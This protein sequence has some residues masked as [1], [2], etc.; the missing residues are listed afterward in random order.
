MPSLRLHTHIDP[1]LPRLAWCARVRAYSADVVVHHGS[2]VEV[3]EQTLVDGAWDG[4]FAQMA[5]AS[6]T[7]MAGTGLSAR[8]GRLRF[9]SGSGRENRIY[10]ARRGT[11]LFVSNS[12]TFTLVAAGDSPDPTHRDHAGE[13]RRQM[14]FGPH[15]HTPYALPF[16]GGSV[17]LFELRDFEVG[18][19]LDLTET[20]RSSPPPPRNYEELFAQLDTIVA[21]TLANAMDPA[22]RRRYSPLATLSR[23]YDAAATA[24]FAARN[25]CFEAITFCEPGSGAADDDGTPIGEALGLRVLRRPRLAWRTRT[26]L[27]EAEMCATP[28]AKS[29]P[30]SSVQDD[31]AGRIVMT[32][33]YGDSAFRRTEASPNPV[34]LRTNAWTSAPSVQELRLRVGFIYCSPLYALRTNVRTI[35][36]LSNSAQLAPFWVGGDYDRPIARRIVEDAG[37]DRA[38]FGQQKIAGAFS[39]VRAPHQL[40]PI[41]RRDFEDFVANTRGLPSTR[42]LPLRI[43]ANRT[44]ELARRLAQ[45]GLRHVDLPPLPPLGEWPAIDDPR[46]FHWGFAHTR[47]RYDGRAP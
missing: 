2:D 16:R 23:G 5:F 34:R 26:D 35:I 30:F 14:R 47:K 9:V 18:P 27:P 15:G 31:L 3:G 19:T 17:D 37:V 12:L 4:E 7:F 39:D 45:R 8:D 1:A 32:G 28:P 24:V 25:Q 21:R 11:D 22:R 38:L 13:I 43:A 36:A 33:K 6:A 20:T 46:L 42:D 29:L 40:G 44:L 10:A 41:S